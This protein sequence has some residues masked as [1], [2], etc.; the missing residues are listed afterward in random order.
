MLATER[1]GE[2]AMDAALSAAG[3]ECNP[4]ELVVRHR[5]AVSENAHVGDLNY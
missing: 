5:G 1:R 2:K 4:F 3:C